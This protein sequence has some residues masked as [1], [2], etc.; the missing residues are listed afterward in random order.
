[1]RKFSHLTV[2]FSDVLS[3][4]K[5][6]KEFKCQTDKFSAF[7]SYNQTIDEISQIT[8][9]KQASY[10]KDT[11]NTLVSVLEDQY[12]ET[13]YYADVQQQLR[14][15]T[16]EQTFTICSAHQPVIFGGPLYTLYKIASSINYAKKLN[17]RYQGKHFVPIYVMGTED[18]DFEEIAHFHL[19]GNKYD[20][21]TPNVIGSAVG[22]M[23]LDGIESLIAPILAKFERS[24]FRNEVTRLVNHAYSSKKTVAQATRDFYHI[25]FRGH[26]LIII[27][28][29]DTRLKELVKPVFKNEILDRFSQPL[30][31]KRQD[32]LANQGYSPQIH[33]R[34][35]NLFYN[36]PA[37]RTRIEKNDESY[38][39]G[40]RAFSEK[41]M[42]GLLD[43]D[44]GNFSTNVALRPIFQ[45][46]CLP[47][48]AFIG[49]GA[50][51]AYWLE[52]AL[53][54]DAN[55]VILPQL[56]R[57]NSFFLT[58]KKSQKRLSELNIE[59]TQVIRQDEEDLV[60]LIL[61]QEGE[62]LDF[63]AEW[64]AYFD[65]AFA[66]L[67]D[68]VSQH[69][70]GLDQSIDAQKAQVLKF[71][72]KLNK[73]VVKSYKNRNASKLNTLNRAYKELLP[74]QKAQERLHNVLSYYA[75]FGPDLINEIVN[76]ADV[77]SPDVLVIILEKD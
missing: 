53:I 7:Y 11:R 63:S 10:S 33:S 14:M 42:M 21:E 49:G 55:Q 71:L 45:E 43:S 64:P 69:E 66:Q 2:P 1:M 52:I 28:M 3:F 17:D 54:F 36:S 29:D 8:L 26:G 58:T 76:Q 51:M 68:D 41:E 62:Q 9:Q 77:L 65:S 72:D 13:S 44:I 47:N 40:E 12:N 5:R 57:R 22:R 25:L 73:K 56:L 61:A 67:K 16:S 4:G 23:K 35:I 70:K 32:Q 18:H 27:D 6:D 48:V 31:T 38:L 60:R 19:Y 39:I 46:T 34:E 74:S 75:D 24:K 20:W 59:I 15:L 30:I 37:G 50:E